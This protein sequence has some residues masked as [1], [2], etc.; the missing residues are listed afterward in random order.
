VTNGTDFTTPTRGLVLKLDETVFRAS[1]DVLMVDCRLGP[2]VI[3]IELDVWGILSD[4][5]GQGRD[6]YR[7]EG[8]EVVEALDAVI[9]QDDRP[10]LTVMRVPAQQVMLDLAGHVRGLGP[11]SLEVDAPPY[12]G[13]RMKM[14]I[15]SL[16]DRHFQGSERSLKEQGVEVVSVRESGADDD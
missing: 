1:S 7:D 10:G 2:D 3:R 13:G 11:G 16:L 8:V 6:A 14:S 4:Y 15:R 5:H 9:F 12:M